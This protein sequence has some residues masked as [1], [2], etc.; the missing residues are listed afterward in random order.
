MGKSL[1]SDLSDCFSTKDLF[2]TSVSISVVVPSV[3]ALESVLN[4]FSSIHANANADSWCEWYAHE[5]M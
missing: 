2:I 1:S 5:S 3:D 4:P